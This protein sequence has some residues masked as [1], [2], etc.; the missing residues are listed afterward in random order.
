MRE[1]NFSYEENGEKVNFRIDADEKKDAIKQFN[2]MTEGD[3]IIS[4]LEINE[5]TKAKKESLSVKEG[6]NA[7]WFALV[8]T[9]KDYKI[10]DELKLN[11][12]EFTNRFR[13]H[14]G[15]DPLKQQKQFE[16]KV[17]EFYSKK[18]GE[19]VYRLS[20]QN[21]KYVSATPAPPEGKLEEY[22]SGKEQASHEIKELNDNKDLTGKVFNKDLY[23]ELTASKN[24]EI[25]E[26]NQMI[27]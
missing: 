24:K 27:Y 2:E 9:L 22:Y 16:G 26:G 19:T 23:S 6:Q 5:I 7:A 14:L 25:G 15:L 12:T 17:V 1:W 11:R 3:S 20:I 10:G 8:E 13:E 21:E 18:S 4:N